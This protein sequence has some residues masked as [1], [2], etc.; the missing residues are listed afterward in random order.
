MLSGGGVQGDI[1]AAEMLSIDRSR[2]KGNLSATHARINNLIEG[3]VT[4]RGSLEPSARG[5][6][7]GQYHGCGSEASR[8]SVDERTYHHLACEAP[9]TTPLSRPTRGRNSARRK[10]LLGKRMPLSNS[11]R[12][13]RDVCPD[14]G[15][16]RRSGGLR[17]GEEM[18]TVP[19]DDI[20]RFPPLRGGG[21]VK[22]TR[23]R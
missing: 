19:E 14:G 12:S 21:A 13:P 20:V 2:I 10:P 18:M 22:V 17:I 7:S 16:T 4:V 11:S 1:A 3:D 23:S 5:R 15:E 9:E 8:R 6:H